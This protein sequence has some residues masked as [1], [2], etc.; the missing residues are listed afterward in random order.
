MKRDE[1][2]AVA[3]ELEDYGFPHELEMEQ[4]FLDGEKE[5]LEDYLKGIVADT[6]RIDIKGIFSR[7]GSGREAIHFP[8]EEIYTPLKTLKNPLDMER[9][10]AFV[11]KEDYSERRVPLTELLS[12][13]RRLLIIGEPGGGKTT[14]LR[15]IACVLAKD[16]L[17]QSEP[18]RKRHLGLSLEEDAPV[19]RFGENGGPCR[20][21]G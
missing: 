6:R 2:A 13:Y 9:A 7:S 21:D 16:A 17:G 1:W 18:G 8:I 3:D 11:E 12:D 5:P 10:T 4:G 20:D 15:L 19:P 14:F